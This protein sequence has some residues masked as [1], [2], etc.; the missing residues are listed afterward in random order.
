M[1]FCHIMSSDYTDPEKLKK[2]LYHRHTATAIILERLIRRLGAEEQLLSLRSNYLQ[3]PEEYRQRLIDIY[4]DQLSIWKSERQG[5]ESRE[6]RR[7]WKG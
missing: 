2:N 4:V 7:S 5:I 6:H 3:S 1:V